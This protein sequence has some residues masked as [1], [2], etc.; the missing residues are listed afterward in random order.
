MKEWQFS[1]KEKERLQKE[2]VTGKNENVSWK[3]KN[4]TVYPT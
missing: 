2:V 4:N 3:Q 1:K